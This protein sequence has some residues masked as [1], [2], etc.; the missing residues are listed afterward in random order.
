MI[1]YAICIFTQQA[2]KDTTGG[3]GV[4]DAGD[5][6]RATDTHK[7]DVWLT[8]HRNSVWIRKTN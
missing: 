4:G 2:G 5:T 3:G 7:S 6:K 8:V 1:N